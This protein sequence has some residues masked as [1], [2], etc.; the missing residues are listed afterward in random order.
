MKSLAIVT[1][2]FLA[3]I[4]AVAVTLTDANEQPQPKAK[5]LMHVKLDHAQELIEGLATEDYNALAK[6]S[7]ALTLLSQETDWSVIQTREYRRLSEEFRRNSD[8]LTKAAK[9]RNLDGATLAY[10]GLTMKCVECHKYV[11]SYNSEMPN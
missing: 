6:H 3:G 10:V 2:V 7:N 1:S 9:N 4:L 11:R 5:T 8:Q